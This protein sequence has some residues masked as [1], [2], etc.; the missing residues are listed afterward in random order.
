ML[1][2]PVDERTQSGFSLIEL[3]AVVAIIGV[4]AAIAVPVFLGMQSRAKDTSV[5]SDL[6]HAKT[7]LAA[8]AAA[9]DGEAPAAVARS[10]AATW[11]STMVDLVPYG[12]TLGSSTS[13]LVYTPVSGSS[14]CLLATSATGGVF[15]VT[16]SSAVVRATSCP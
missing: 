3:I 10:G 11:S 2:E 9:H 13:D 15:R 1:G 12:W 14:W 7:A 5:Q 8:F 6:V 16:P 4:L